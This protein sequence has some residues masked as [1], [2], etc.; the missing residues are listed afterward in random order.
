MA[1]E[2][3]VGGPPAECV[4]RLEQVVAAGARMLMLNA[5]LGLLHPADSPGPAPPSADPR[6]AATSR[7]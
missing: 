3:S 4:E 6:A 1:E 2:V 5:Q 7:P